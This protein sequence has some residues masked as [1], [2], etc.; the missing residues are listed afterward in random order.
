MS[1]NASNPI[2]IFEQQKKRHALLQQRRTRAEALRDAER[3][4][5]ERTRAEAR[6][7][8]GTDDLA[9]LRQMYEEGRQENERKT[10]ELLFE[11]DEIERKLAD[12]ERLTAAAA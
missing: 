8:L 4:S 12:I 11:L 9:K 10:T 5:L 3:E 7:L 2:E 1:T 6:A